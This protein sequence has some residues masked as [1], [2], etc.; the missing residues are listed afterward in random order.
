MR[1][2]LRRNVRA[3]ILVDMVADRDLNIRRDSNSAAWLNEIVWTAAR[4]LEHED[5]FLD[6]AT[7]ITDDHLSF[8]AVGVPAIDIIDLDYAAWHTPDDTLDKVSARSLQTVGDVLLEA[9][10][11]I[12]ARLRRE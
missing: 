10:P 5:V 3:M 2:A 8:T 9:L 11:K 12:E 7:T 1:K 4:R 6:E